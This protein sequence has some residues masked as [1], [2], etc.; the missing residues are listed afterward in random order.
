[1][2]ERYCT[3]QQCILARAN[4]RHERDEHDA[5]VK[6][7]RAADRDAYDVMKAQ[8]ELWRHNYRTIL[9]VQDEENNKLRTTAAEL[10]AR[11][12]SLEMAN[13]IVARRWWSWRS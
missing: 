5:R 11:N 10:S 12:L 6:E 9:S 2:K 8:I 13:K 7:Q 1:M 3:D 4:E